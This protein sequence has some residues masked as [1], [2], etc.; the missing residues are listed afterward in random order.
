MAKV[1]KDIVGESVGA[2]IRPKP[3]T[4]SSHLK[5]PP[6]K[7]FV[8]LVSPTETDM[9]DGEVLPRLVRFYIDP[10]INGVPGVE[11]SE[12]AENVNWRGAVD[13]ECHRNG[14]ILVDPDRYGMEVTVNGK[15]VRPDPEEDSRDPRTWYVKRYLGHK[16][17]VHVSIWET[18]TT[19]GRQVLWAKDLEGEKAFR[20]EVVKKIFGKIDDRIEKATVQRAKFELAEFKNELRRRPALQMNVDIAEKA[21][22]DNK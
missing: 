9:V 12:D 7:D 15:V 16:G 18:P 2:E 13:A 17:Y 21:L 4:G 11:R 6:R 20:R 22:G 8:F 14:R 10:G 5:I 19:L 1:G 3:R